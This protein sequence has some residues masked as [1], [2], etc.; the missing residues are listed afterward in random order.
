VPDDSSS[1]ICVNCGELI[2]LRER[3]SGDGSTEL[4]H[5]ETDL[6]GCGPDGLKGA[7]GWA[8][9]AELASSVIV[10]DL[11]GLDITDRVIAEYGSVRA[12]IENGKAMRAR[13]DEMFV[14]YA[15][16]VDAATLAPE[17]R[18]DL[19]TMA[20]R[21]ITR[22]HVDH[23]ELTNGGAVVV[24]RIDGAA[25]ESLAYFGPMSISTRPQDWD[26]PARSWLFSEAA[27]KAAAR[28]AV[29]RRG[30]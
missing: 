5:V 17:P 20:E 30:Q 6:V 28:R 3:V 10:T 14:E 2:E 18:A 29:E 13:L 27:C 15:R 12:W 23:V 7:T 26:E 16:A 1:G 4:R 9:R 22:L 11:L 24:G 19:P 21:K 25:A 8:P